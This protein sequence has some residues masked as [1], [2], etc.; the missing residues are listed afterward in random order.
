MP[1]M[2]YSACAMQRRREGIGRYDI[3][4][5]VEIREMDLADLIGLAEIEQIVAFSSL[6]E[7]CRILP[8]STENPAKQ[9]PLID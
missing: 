7:S 1:A 6:D 2:S 8:R 9:I 5:G 3:G 4:A